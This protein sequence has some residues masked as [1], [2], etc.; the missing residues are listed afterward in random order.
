MTYDVA[1]V[2]GQIAG[3]DEAT[4]KPVTPAELVERFCT[5]EA[6]QGLVADPGTRTNDQGIIVSSGFCGYNGVR[7]DDSFVSGFDDGYDFMGNLEAAGWRPLTGKGDWPLAVY[8]RWRATTDTKG[9]IAEYVE[10]DLTVW[11]FENHEQAKRFYTTLR[12]QA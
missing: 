12:N 5:A 8:M 4:H 2:V 10:G 6:A 3:L 9:A 1:S 11:Q 7:S